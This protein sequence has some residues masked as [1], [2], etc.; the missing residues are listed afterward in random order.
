MQKNF[1][2]TF[3]G[4]LPLNFINQVQPYGVLIVLQRSTLHV[5]QLSQNV[6]E[7]LGLKVDDILE[8]P[9]SEFITD[10]QCSKLQQLLAAA[11]NEKLP[12]TFSFNNTG[13]FLGII[14][15][16]DD[17][18]VIELEKIGDN[19]SSSFLSIY[20]RLKHAM[21]AI[22]DSDTI[23]AVCKTTVE[24]FKKVSGFDKVMIYRFD[25][26]WN[27][28]VVAEVKE[29]G[30][31]AY[32]GL[33]FPASDIPKQARELYY[34]NVYRQIPNRDF[35]PVKLVPVI[36]PV[37]EAF[38]DLADCNLRS[39]AAVHLEYLKNMGVVA[40]MSIRIVKDNQL[41]G[42]I[43]CHHK[44]PK[45]LNYEVCSVFELLSGV[46]SQKISMLENED[47]L[48]YTNYLKGV[49]TRLVEQIYNQDDY[50]KG[51]LNG[52][53]TIAD[54][55]QTENVAIIDGKSLTTKGTVPSK[56]SLDELVMWLQ[57]LDINNVFHATNLSEVYDAG[58]QITGIASGMIVLP[59]NPNRGTYI[60]GF[61]P[62][63]IQVVD[64]GGNP[65]EAIQFEPDRK[66]YHP[67]N[68]FGIWQETV[69]NTSLPW[70]KE[71]IAV[72]ESFRNVLVEFS[73]RKL[74]ALS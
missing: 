64:W 32:M 50:V 61:K 20:Q 27:G 49:Q 74:S 45:F 66:N 3:C 71:E 35:T 37:T 54:L 38:T 73:L 11:T 17:V 70:S 44:T 63:V 55:L 52:D 24:E 47:E 46:V 31:D 39:V 6:E 51:L 33:R 15:A 2:S 10:E 65:N 30:M 58:S 29:E 25:E 56:Q 5:V 60:L 21:A 22:N 18:I 72:A 53:S 19:S 1:D 23:E 14:H 40:S 13:D 43:S 12:L 59:I 69:K 57:G 9:F 68:S 67:R 8:Q 62:E 48:N 16:K 41:W 26:Q 4:S 28:T 34:R 42:L 36:N 7:M